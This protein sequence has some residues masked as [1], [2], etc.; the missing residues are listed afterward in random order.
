MR[1]DF[2][3][4]EAL[5]LVGAYRYRIATLR[6]QASLSSQQGSLAAELCGSGRGVLAWHR[7]IAADTLAAAPR[8]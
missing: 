3:S 1:S 5:L 4:M 2:P 8:A 7:A 6:R